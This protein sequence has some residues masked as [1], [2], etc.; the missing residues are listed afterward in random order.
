MTIEDK[1]LTAYFGKDSEYFIEKYNLYK[2][3]YK[4]SFSAWPFFFGVHWFL[5]RK[6][7]IEAIAVL[8]VY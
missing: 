5:Y 6:L 4:F 8:I 3:G 2:S 1:Y 7:W